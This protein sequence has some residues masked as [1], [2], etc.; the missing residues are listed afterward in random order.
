MEILIRAIVE[1]LGAPKEHIEKTLKDYVQKIKENKKIK[2]LSEEYAEP[3]EVQK[4]YSVFVELELRF[5]EMD[6][7]INFCFD[8]M[9]SSIEI[10]EPEE[11]VLRSSDMTDFLNDLQ[12]RLHKVDGMLKSMM[13]ENKVLKK[14]GLTIVK[15]V[16]V[17]ALK[18][19]PKDSEELSKLTGLPK[20]HLQKFLNNLVKQNKIKEENGRYILP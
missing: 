10:I 9:P 11:V 16:I 1:M 2:V 6:E 20:D 5:K 3:K 18:D 8:Y 14:N 19:G 4:L 13:A 12:G 15:N 7:I 17:V